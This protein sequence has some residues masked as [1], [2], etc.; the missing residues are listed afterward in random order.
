[1]SSHAIASIQHSIST[2]QTKAY[3]NLFLQPTLANM[4]S[5]I[6]ENVCE[7]IKITSSFAMGVGCWLMLPSPPRSTGNEQQDRE[8]QRTHTGYSLALAAGGAFFMA[9]A[10]GALAGPACSSSG[11]CASPSTASPSAATKP[12]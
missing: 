4:T 9:A 12:M 8:G 5:T 7:A 11:K 1:L 10:V 2:S 3:D 6:I